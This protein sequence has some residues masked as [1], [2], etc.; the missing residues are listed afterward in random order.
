MNDNEYLQS[1]VAAHELDENSSEAAAVLTVK[2]DVEKLIRGK[3]TSAVPVIEIAGS[4][5]KGTMIRDHY[6]LDVVCYFQNNETEAGGTLEEIYNTIQD[7][8]SEEYTVTPKNAALFLSTKDDNGVPLHVDV[9]PGRFVDDSQ[10]DCFLYQNDGD[11]NRLQTN[12]RTHISHVKESGLTDAI[13]LAKYWRHRRGFDETIRSFVLELVVI[14]VLK[15][16]KSSSLDQQMTSFLTAL[17]DDIDNVKIVD[18][19]NATGNDLSTAFSES[20]RSSLQKAA[21]ATLISVENDG[22][23]S[24]FPTSAKTFSSD[25]AARIENVTRSVPEPSKLWLE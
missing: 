20:I 25:R 9:V 1:V 17:R 14:E 5:A 15:D 16:K 22:W 11:K 13:K 10:T 23:E 3:L 4:Y 18:P 12:L 19:A 2:N 7:F 6:D 8:L 21:K 24:V